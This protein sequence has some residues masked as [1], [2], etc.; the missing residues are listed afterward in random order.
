[1]EPADKSHPPQ[2][3][4]MISGRGESSE[5]ALR[6][7]LTRRGIDVLP[8]AVGELVE[9]LTDESPDLLLLIGD[10]ADDGGARMLR[11]IS[12]GGMS[13]LVPIVT[14]VDELSPGVDYSAFLA[15]TVGQ[16]VRGEDVEEI[17]RE[18]ALIVNSMSDRTGSVEVEIGAGEGASSALVQMLRGRAGVLQCV[19]VL[20]AVLWKQEQRAPG[21]GQPA[22]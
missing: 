20:L 15:G 6:V 4:V 2:P 21:P 10:D 3:R 5:I 8:P 17:A 18:V 7:A 12:N 14:L 9:A 11:S 16:V 13:A 22:V 19:C 1:M